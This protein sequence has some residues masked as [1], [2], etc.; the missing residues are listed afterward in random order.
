MIKSNSIIYLFKC[1]LKSPKAKYKISNSKRQEEIH[2]QKTERRPVSFSPQKQFDYRNYAN[3]SAV[4]KSY[5]CP[6]IYIAY[7]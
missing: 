3:H 5:I 2:K 7:N 6:Y 4:R 1:L